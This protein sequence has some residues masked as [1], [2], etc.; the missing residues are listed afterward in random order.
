ML[1]SD[2]YHAARI[3]DIAERGRPRRGDIADEHEP[4]LRAAEWRRF[5]T[6]TLRVAAG[7]IFGYRRLEQGRE[8]GELVPGLGMLSAFGGGVIGNTTGSGPVIGGSSPPP[9]ASTVDS[10]VDKPRWCRR[11]NTPPSQGGDHGFESRTGCSSASDRFGGGADN[12][13]PQPSKLVVHGRNF[14][15][16]RDFSAK[17]ISN[18]LSGRH[19][20]RSDAG[21]ERA[22]RNR[23]R[24]ACP[25]GTNDQ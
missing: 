19:T 9:R 22:T 12:M 1:V 23:G 16:F 10:S 24:R 15:E 11:P 18:T 20:A 21:R 4:D 7:R 5:G 6:E 14:P 17:A 25:T 2:P 3:D 8:M 13:C